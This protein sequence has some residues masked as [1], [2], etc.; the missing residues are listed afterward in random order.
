MAFLSQFFRGKK[1]TEIAERVEQAIAPVPERPRPARAMVYREGHVVYE[2]GYRRKGIVLDYSDS[3]LRLRFPTN[4]RLPTFVTVSARA[5]GL[6]GPA[7]VIWQ[8]G[9]E[10]GLKLI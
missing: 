4:E 2:S 8:H 1:P 7:E 3:G 6:E 9:S 5:V 10:A